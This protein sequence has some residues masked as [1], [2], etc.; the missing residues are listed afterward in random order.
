[1]DA[2]CRIRPM[3]VHVSIHDPANAMV[4]AYLGTSRGLQHLPVGQSPDEVDRWHLGTHPDVVD[5]LWD[6]LNAAL[7]EDGRCAIYGG[8]ALVDPASGVVLAVG[9]GTQYAIRLQAA[10]RAEALADGAEVIHTFATSGGTLDLVATLGADWVFGSFDA[11]EPGWLAAACAA[12][13]R[14]ALPVRAQSSEPSTTEG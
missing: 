2:D 1:M 11:R 10:D 13:G 5:R 4:L 14:E 6:V 9:I 12:A 3:V 7:P 8:P